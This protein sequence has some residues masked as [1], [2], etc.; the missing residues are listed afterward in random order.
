MRRIITILLLS[1]SG[2]FSVAEG[3][4]HNQDVSVTL[5]K[6]FSRLVASHE[7]SE[8][9]RIN[10]SVKLI[11][12]S[13]SETD[14]VFTHKF[15]NLKYL[16]QVTSKN[17]GLKI[18]TWNL[19][20]KDSA[21]RYFCY[22]IN[23]TGKK[24]NLYRLEGRYNDS[25]LK[26]DITYSEKDWYGAVYYDLRAFKQNKHPYWVLLGIDYGNPKITRK[27]IDILSFGPDGKIVFGKKLFVSE[28]VIKYREVL[29]YS[30]EVVI[31]LRFLTDKSIIFDHLV[32][33]S[34]GLKGNK[35]FYGPDFSFD[36]YNLE[37]G[38]W[39]LKSDVDVRNKK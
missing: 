2:I 19:L 11:I 14:T 9:L 31:S 24:N 12:D 32:P 29:E 26:T 18:I 10:D 3:Q 30:S 23:S 17:S 13:Y 20:L 7:D 37:K 35:E 5:E 39:K 4:T 28:D 15:T 22:L 36:T 21:S 16:G 25:P 34:P 8:K 27:I 38:V 1:A 6:L 33:L